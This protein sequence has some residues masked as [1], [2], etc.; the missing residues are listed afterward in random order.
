V[1]GA[2]DLAAAEGLLTATAAEHHA[3][4]MWSADVVTA[5]GTHQ[6]ALLHARRGTLDPALLGGPAEWPKEQLGYLNKEAYA[7]LL[8][9]VGRL[10]EVRLA[11][12]PWEHQPPIDD[13]FVMLYWLAL[14]IEIWARLGD[15][16]ACADLY[17]QAL[18]YAG[19]MAMAGLSML[20]WPISRSLALL[21]RALGD[22]EAALRHAGQALETARRMGADALVE[23]IIGEIAE[24]GREA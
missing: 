17:A 14:R 24:I 22:T 3:T 6:I 20:M 10:D 23:L 5:G 18:P 21:A 11:L 1:L 7:L 9:T 2:G 13:T 8:V 12:G 15:Q 4:S 19:R 16:E